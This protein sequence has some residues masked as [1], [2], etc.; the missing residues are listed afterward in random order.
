LL[1]CPPRTSNLLALH[2]VLAA[3]AGGS[4][5]AFAMKTLFRGP[6]IVL[7]GVGFVFLAAT[8]ALAL[9]GQSWFPD[10]LILDAWLLFHLVAGVGLVALSMRFRIRLALG[11]AVLITIGVL[12]SWL[13]AIAYNVERAQSLPAIVVIAIACLGALIG[14]LPLWG[15][16]RRHRIAVNKP[17]WARRP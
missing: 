6:R 15:A 1:A 14:V 8:V 13:Q 10:A 9:L 2:D 5:F 11:L 12:L 3:F 16:V 4:F 17:A 7:G